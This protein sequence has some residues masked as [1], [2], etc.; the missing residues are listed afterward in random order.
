MQLLRLHLMVGM[1][2]HN[3]KD[4]TSRTQF[5]AGKHCRLKRAA[6]VQRQHT[7]FAGLLSQQGFWRY[8]LVESCLSSVCR[9]NPPLEYERECA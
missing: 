7:R 4:A 2:L 1:S 5:V 6:V 3:A 9:Q 8:V